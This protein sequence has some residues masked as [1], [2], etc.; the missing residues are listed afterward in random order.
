MSPARTERRVR[1]PHLIAAGAACLGLAVAPFLLMA[2]PLALLTLALAYG[3]FAFGL[4]LAWGRAGVVSIGHAAFFGIGAYSVAIAVDHELPMALG[5]L[6]GVVLAVAVALLVGWIGL[7]PR[8]LPSTMAI[9]TLA[10]TLLAEQVALSW[11]GTTGGSN[12]LTVSGSGV[13]IDYYRTAIIV[14]VVVALVWFWVI[15][16]RWGR[17]FL[18]VQS[19]AARAEHFG[20]NPVTTRV[21]S[22]CLSAGVAAVAGAAAA[23]IMRLVSPGVTG[24]LLSAQVLVWLAVGGR[25]TIAGAFIGAAAVSIGQQYLGDAVGGWYLLVLG[26]LFILVVRFAPTGLMGAVRALVRRPLS[27]TAAQGTRL[28]AAVVPVAAAEADEAE[29]AGAVSE[30]DETGPAEGADPAG[31]LAGDP[32]RALRTAGVSKSYGATEVLAGVDLDVAAG[33]IVCLIGPN[34]AGKTTLLDIIAGDRP[35]DGGAVWLFGEDIAARSIGARAQAGLGK[36]FQIPSVFEDLTPAQNLQ[37][38]VAESPDPVPVPRAYARF[39]DEGSLLAKDL[40]L[41][42][43][44]ALELAMVMTWNPRVVL[45]DEPAAGLSHEES[46]N[47]ARRLRAVALRTGCTVVV[48]EHD[49]EIV[50]ELADRVIVLVGGAIL[51]DGSMDAVSANEDV[52]RAYLEVGP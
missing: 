41:A 20:I 51:T 50:R 40:P 35:P 18:A 8:T 1:R 30:A 48:V 37:I 12:G 14:V 22:L 7:G 13:V 44:R 25:G 45:L 38:A 43:R 15:R 32:A 17:R 2:Y 11:R 29:L 47:L 10:L 34:G 46:V 4:D 28:A 23:P 31:D 27:E 36:V 6:V 19:N 5:T 9:L 26:V 52:R 16:G 24:I 33:E 39:R 21:F 3:L 49:M 42:D